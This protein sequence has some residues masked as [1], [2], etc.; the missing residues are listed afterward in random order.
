MTSNTEL[1]AGKEMKASSALLGIGLVA[2]SGLAFHFWHKLEDERQ[3][4]AILAQ[5]VSERESPAP[6]AA[7]PI[8]TPE[9][10][11]NDA[12]PPLQASKEPQLSERADRAALLAK[13]IEAAKNR[14]ASPEGMALRKA[15]LRQRQGS[16][17]PDVG[18]ALGLTTEEA[19]KLLDLITNQRMR[20]SSTLVSDSESPQDREARERKE[21]ETED[22]ELQTLLGS[23]YAKWQDYRE[24]LPAWVQRSDLRAVLDAAGVPLA[25]SQDK[26]VIDALSAEQRIINHTHAS[27][28]QG[29]SNGVLPQ[30]TPENRQRFLDAVAPY[31]S[32][33]QLDGYKGLLERKATQEQITLAIQQGWPR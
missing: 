1:E 30:Y 13:T 19:D 31:L 15:N 3:Q 25:K 11:S 12:E 6:I 18:E 2:V 26:A 5:K 29:N 24:N 27:T 21:R 16:V 28:S 8:Q 7:S 22:A 10:T 9:R 4:V 14:L 20:S 23:K 33:Q 17:Y 32:P